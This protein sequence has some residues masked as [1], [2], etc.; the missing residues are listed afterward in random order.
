M[1]RQPVLGLGFL[2]A[3]FSVWIA[4]PTEQEDWSLHVGVITGQVLDLEGN[5]ISNAWVIATAE[6][7]GPV[8][9][10]DTDEEGRFKLE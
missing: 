8:P 2:L 4:T 10:I 7:S 5:P 3:L 6:V 9:S 1:M